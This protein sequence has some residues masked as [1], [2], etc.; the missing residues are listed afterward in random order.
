M[1]RIL[2]H[3]AANNINKQIFNYI[4]NE[5]NKNI[6]KNNSF[7]TMFGSINRLII[8]INNE[9]K[10]T[11]EIKKFNGIEF[12]NIT[13]VMQE[14]Y[15]R[16][17]TQTIDKIN[18]NSK[19]FDNIDISN[20]TQLDP[21]ELSRLC[22][23]IVNHIDTK[24]IYKEV[25]YYIAV[26]LVDRIAESVENFGRYALPLADFFND[27]TPIH[28]LPESYFV[29]WIRTNQLKIKEIL[30]KLIHNTIP[31]LYDNYIDY[32]F[33]EE[34]NENGTSPNTWIEYS[35]EQDPIHGMRE[36]DI[37][38]TYFSNIRISPLVVLDQKVLKSRNSKA[39]HNELIDNYREELKLKENDDNEL[40]Y[41]S[42]TET[43]LEEFGAKNMAI[44][45]LFNGNVALL[46]YITDGKAED[47]VDDNNLIRPNNGDPSV[48]IN[49]LQNEGIKKIY[50]QNTSPWVSREYER[51][52]KKLKYN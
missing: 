52:A 21:N 6:L 51:I 35:D 24:P 13:Y 50:L 4:K 38:P 11:P 18:T 28:D 20:I 25:L 14:I 27:N 47:I 17:S 34:V 12:A 2:Y 48:I 39:H 45:S 29:T 43:I 40:A 46:E 23:F 7:L 16:I 15:D 22:K 8:N 41:T 37:A 33:S 44:G 32:D 31:I 49:A 19:I 10:I 26:E 36:S 5:A 42:G 9:F 3:L 1:N 30:D